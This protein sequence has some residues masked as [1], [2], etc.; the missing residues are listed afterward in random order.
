MVAIISFVPAATRLCLGLACMRHIGGTKKIE[1]LARP[2][3]I[4]KLSLV[5]PEGPYA[6]KTTR[7]PKV[8]A[9]ASKPATIASRR[10]CLFSGLGRTAQLCRQFLHLS[11]LA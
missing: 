5:T 11:Y 1:L 7:M 3:N 4:G 6:A 8:M 9:Q 2:A 10:S